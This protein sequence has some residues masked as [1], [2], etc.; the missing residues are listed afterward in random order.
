MCKLETI[1]QN[2]R[3][4]Q[5]L[6]KRIA[7]TNAVRV[8]SPEFRKEWE[9][10]CLEFHAAFDRLAFPGGSSAIKAVQNGDPEAI[11]VAISFLLADPY[12]LRSG[13]LKA[14][15]WR[16][17]QRSKL[18]NGQLV[19]LEKAAL[20][21]LDRRISREF[22]NMCTAMA[23]LGRSGFWCRV[24]ERAMLLGT[25]EGFRALCGNRRAF[26]RKVRKDR[27]YSGES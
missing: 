21:Y 11:N 27:T 3:E 6:W 25:P 23:R 12:H 9:K 20:K 2:S 8:R 26:Y 1:E 19:R 10:A 13:Y 4:L 22:W 14:D 7:S 16:W 15:I 17:I 18:G 24:T 5:R